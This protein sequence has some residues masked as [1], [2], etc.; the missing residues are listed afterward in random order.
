MQLKLSFHKE[1]DP[2]RSTWSFGSVGRLSITLAKVELTL[3]LTLT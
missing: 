1:I 3:T 2:S